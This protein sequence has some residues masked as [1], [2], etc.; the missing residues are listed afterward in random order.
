MGKRGPPPQPPN[1]VQMRGTE[2]SDRARE[3]IV[4]PVEGE[5]V[6][7]P[8]L[9][10]EALELFWRKVSTYQARGQAVVG[11]EDAIAHYAA[12]ETEIIDL[13]ARR[14]EVPAAQR[15]LLLRFQTQ[16]YDTAAA[17]V[18]SVTPGKG[19]NAFSKNGVTKKP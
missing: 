13:M 12:L 7:P 17:Q 5:P 15:Q 18:G 11:L 6:P 3:F 16:F 9:G 8:W 2:R 19:G 14:V 1:V 10:G 4:E